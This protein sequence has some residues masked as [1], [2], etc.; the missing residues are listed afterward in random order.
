MYLSSC[1]NALSLEISSQ[2]TCLAHIGP[3]STLGVSGDW[4]TP[5]WIPFTVFLEHL[6]DLAI[7][8]SDNPISIN[9]LISKYLITVNFFLAIKASFLD[10]YSHTAPL[11]WI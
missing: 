3:S 5:P 10:I 4:M 11:G 8:R 6:S 7:C 2:L 9:L 1:P